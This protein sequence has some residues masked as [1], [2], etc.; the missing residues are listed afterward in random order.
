MVKSF[1]SLRRFRVIAITKYWDSV[2][3]EWW[4]QR[5][6]TVRGSEAI[7]SAD[8]RDKKKKSKLKKDDTN[9]RIAV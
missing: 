9:Q 1:V 5:Q 2:E 8:K 6:K 7:D 4:S 3:G